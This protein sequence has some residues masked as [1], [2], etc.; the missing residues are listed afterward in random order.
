[1]ASRSSSVSLPRTT[2]FSSDLRSVPSAA[3]TFESLRPRT[4]TSSPA[5]A[6]T[7]TMPVAIVP[8]PTTPTRCTSRTVTSS[9]RAPVGVSASGTTFELC[10]S[11]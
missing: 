6:S 1:M 5:L 8:V 7:S 9:G 11:A 10:A 2:P 4:T 3:A